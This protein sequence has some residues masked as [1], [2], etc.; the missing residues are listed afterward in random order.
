[1]MSDFN[2]NTKKEVKMIHVIDAPTGQGKTNAAIN[3]INNHEGRYLFVTP[4][5][6]EL[7]RVI[8]ACSE[9]RFYQ[10]K[11][12]YAEENKV[13]TKKNGIRELFK[14]GVNIVT[15]HAMFQLFDSEM[16]EF[17]K[18]YGY[19][20]ILDEVTNV[21]EPYEELKA[22][23]LEIML[24]EF[25][26]VD[27]H[28]L[29][30]REDQ[31]DYDGE[32]FLKEKGLCEMGCLYL[33]G[34]TTMLWQFSVDIFKAF[35]ESFLLTYMF[36]GQIQKYYYDYHNLKYDRWYVKG[37]SLDTYELTSVKQDY[38]KPSKY[39]PLIEIEDNKKLNAIGDEYY[40]LSSNWYSLK[41]NKGKVDQVRKR[42]V[43]YYNHYT[44]G[45]AETNLWT[46]F[47]DNKKALKGNGYSKGFL[48]CNAKATNLYRGK[49]NLAYVI[50]A[51]INP[52]IQV[53]FE[54]SGI[55]V[56]GDMFALSSLV[57][58]VWRSAIRDGK[59]IKLYIP[60]SR[61][62]NLFISWLNDEV[63]IEWE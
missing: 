26:D 14:A 16:I 12:I 1:M 50:N 47:K 10:P 43:N 7:E 49:S 6:T 20:L 13:S 25:V 27:N 23:D 35:K 4:Y 46:C 15:T 60:S 45:N 30:W 52:N 51:F 57:Q 24:E 28:L 8:K 17:C 21:A 55:P 2:K 33:Y 44:D 61:M 22:D 40:A 3:Y 48:S 5:I 56:D 42:L 11:V 54:D 41:E 34:K 63:D 39:K 37:N 58:W 62:R 59:P 53:F 36:N 29:R 9:K 32:K 18:Q 38:G 19:I 31:K